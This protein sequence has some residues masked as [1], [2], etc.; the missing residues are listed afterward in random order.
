MFQWLGNAGRY[1]TAAIDEAL[2]AVEALGGN[3]GDVMRMRMFAANQED[4][5]RIG[6]M[7]V[8]SFNGHGSHGD[9]ETGTAAT[10][11]VVGGFVD[12]EMLVEIELDAVVS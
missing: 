4:T 1:A 7:F 9:A 3:A 11:L 5:D 8:K 10:M 6:R 2:Q 12:P